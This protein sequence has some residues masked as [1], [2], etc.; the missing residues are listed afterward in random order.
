MGTFE[1]KIQKPRG[2]WQIANN[3]ISLHKKCEN[4]P[5][6]LTAA[7]IH[8]T[9]L[10]IFAG[11]AEGRTK[12]AVF[13][14]KLGQKVLIFRIFMPG[15]DWRL[16]FKS[17]RQSFGCKE[18]RMAEKKSPKKEKKKSLFL[19]KNANFLWLRPICDNFFK[20]VRQPGQADVRSF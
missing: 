9:A 15:A 13:F 20:T 3:S 1:S 2:F 18:N 5:F 16:S 8:Q 17:L 7:K 10:G 14:Y 12:K 11:A 19:P 4:F 6:F